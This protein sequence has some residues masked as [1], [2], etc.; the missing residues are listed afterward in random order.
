MHGLR[1][2]RQA[3]KGRKGARHQARNERARHSRL[4]SGGL[5]SL[6]AIPGH[7][8][9]SR[10]AGRGPFLAYQGRSVVRG[11]YHPQ[12]SVRRYVEAR[13]AE[14]RGEASLSHAVNDLKRFCDAFGTRPAAEITADELRDWIAALK[15]QPTTKRNHHKHGTALFQWAIN[16]GILDE[17]PFANVKPPPFLADEVSVLSVEDATKLFAAALV[18]RPDACPRLALEAFAGLRVSTACKLTPDCL[19]FTAKGIRIAAEIIKGKRPQYID[20]LPAN[21]WTWLG[22]AKKTDWHLSGKDYE[23]AKSDVFRLA[24][25][26]NPGNVLRHSFCSYHVAMHKDASRTAVI[27]CHTSPT[28]LYRHYK[29]I[30]SAADAA[31]YFAV[32]P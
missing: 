24:G 27:L 26:P 32:T 15:F 21:I 22:R 14:K 6:A 19:D 23:R 5:A 30:A 25:V 2:R 28:I 31:L 7:D 3:P 29:G 16:E 13:T 12:R 17:N 11:C 9:R 10:S 1:Y 20:G 18:H 4:R 8:W